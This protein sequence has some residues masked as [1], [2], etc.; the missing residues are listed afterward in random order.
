MI[1]KKTVYCVMCDDC[2]SVAETSAGDPHIAEETVL[3]NGWTKEDLGYMYFLY[4]PNCI[5]KHHK[6]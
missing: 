1:F 2:H 5:H 3:R 6:R 4:C